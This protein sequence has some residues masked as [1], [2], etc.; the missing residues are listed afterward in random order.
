M[1]AIDLFLSIP[2][3]V[4]AMSTMGFPE[5]T[6]L[7]GMPAVTAVWWLWY[8]RLVFNVK[9]SESNGGYVLAAETI[10]ASTAHILFLE[11]LPNC[12]PSILTR[13]T[14]DVGFVALMVASLSFGLGVQ[15]PTPD[16]GSMVADGAKYMPDSW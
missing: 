5:P 14:L 4:L 8:A 2:P 10:G 12:R 3:L 13:M 6:L 9:R 16:L 15:P 1:R 7:N 11:N